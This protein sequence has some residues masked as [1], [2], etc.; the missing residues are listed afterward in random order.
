MSA[1]VV[2]PTWSLDRETVLT[3]VLA[4]PRALVFQM[5]TQ[6]E[7]VCVWFGPAGFT[8]DVLEMDVRVGG[9]WR[10]TLTAP[11]GTVYDNRVEYREIVPAERLVFDHGKDVD[12]DPDRFRVTVTFDE[13]GDGKTVLTMRHLHASKAHRDA[14]IKFG[15]VELG[16]QTL[17]KL[18]AHLRAQR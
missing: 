8:C 2:D 6:P 12:D 5:W 10:F 17:D 4:A 18:A 9:R 11:D 16:G 1:R 3:R 13:Q 15:A 7:H 14:V